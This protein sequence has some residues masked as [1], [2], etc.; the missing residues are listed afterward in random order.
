MKKKIIYVC[1][2]IIN[3]IFGFIVGK[4]SSKKDMNE[5]K[6][7]LKTAIDKMTD[8]EKQNEKFSTLV[9]EQEK[10]I[11]SLKNENE[12]SAKYIQ[13]IKELNHSTKEKLDQLESSKESI[14]NSLNQLRENNKILL[15]HF[16]STISVI[17]E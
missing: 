1:V 8:I 12:I 13:S 14:Y 7:E 6:Y 17:G 9:E 3:L 2:L 15:E 10:I 5:L 11:N 4:F 16:N